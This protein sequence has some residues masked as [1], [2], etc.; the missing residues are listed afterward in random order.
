MAYTGDPANS[1]TDAVRLLINDTDVAL[2]FLTDDEIT[3]FLTENN[4][5]VRK[6]S[7]AAARTILFKLASY[8]RE[9]TLEL[10]YYGSNFFSQYQEALKL[11][12]TNPE[13]GAIS[14]ATPYAGGISRSDIEENIS[15]VDNYTV[16]VEKSIP[17]ENLN[18]A[19]NNDSPFTLNNLPREGV[20]KI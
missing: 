20:Y 6:A 9:R 10:E 8:V 14:V 11:Y 13:F 7:L 18:T 16:Q 1:N 17:V 12:I 2:P 4:N 5:S 15:T 3:Y 19:V